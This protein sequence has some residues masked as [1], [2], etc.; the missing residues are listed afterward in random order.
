[1][2]REEGG[3]DGGERRCGNDSQRGGVGK[4]GRTRPL[5]GK[6][7]ARKGGV[8][9]KRTR[10]KEKRGEGACRE[11]G[12]GGGSRGRLKHRGAG[13]REGKDESGTRRK[14]GW[15]LSVLMGV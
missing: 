4:R 10:G 2:G 5:G 6:E 14:R 13:D 7:W 1:M 15:P 12:V 8:P 11:G 3:G 9:L